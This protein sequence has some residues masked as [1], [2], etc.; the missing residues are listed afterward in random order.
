[1]KQKKTTGYP[2][3]CTAV[4]IISS[5]LYVNFRLSGSRRTVFLLFLLP[6]G[7]VFDRAVA[8]FGSFIST[9]KKRKVDL[10]IDPIANV[11][12]KSKREPKKK[13]AKIDGMLV[14]HTGGMRIVS[15]PNKGRSFECSCT[16]V[17]KRAAR[18]IARGGV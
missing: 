2:I 7:L 17:S 15:Y 9:V 16:R 10:T 11:A 3:S 4:K 14:G 18:E 5:S 1:M 12:R 13:C 8:T 6:A